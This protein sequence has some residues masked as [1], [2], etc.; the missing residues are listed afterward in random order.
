MSPKLKSLLARV[1][2][3]G[4]VALVGTYMARY[5]PHDQTIAIR[6]GSRAVR[7][8]EG[9]VT[10]RGDD[11]ATVGFSREFPG[12]SPRVVRHTFSAPNGTYTVVISLR[13]DAAGDNNPN[14]IETSFER[15]VSLAG[16]E[17]IVSPD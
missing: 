4:G 3:V 14:R 6:L 10:R 8:L 15:Q 2:L 17:V 9:V 5:A 13:E 7:H 12:S 11:E 1:T 16:G